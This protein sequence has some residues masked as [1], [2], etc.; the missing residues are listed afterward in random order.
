M[1][2]RNVNLAEHYDRF[3]EEQVVSGQFKSASELMRT[4]LRR[5]EQF[6]RLERE[7]LLALRA[8]AVAGF[9][10][11]DKGRAC[12]LNDDVQLAGFVAETGRRAANRQELSP[13]NK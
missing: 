1:P 3:V 9:D 6:R 4:A 7:K 13:G 5:P 2:T 11:L 8:L 10:E 12:I